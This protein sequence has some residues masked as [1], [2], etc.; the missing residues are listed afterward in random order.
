MVA[1]LDSPVWPDERVDGPSGSLYLGRTCYAPGASVN[2]EA[3]GH[4]GRLHRQFH[5][6]DSLF[7][8][9]TGSSIHNGQLDRGW[10]DTL[11]L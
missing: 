11:I 7:A 10:D 8:P 6:A 1:K 5:E 4:L 2:H 9:E 3:K